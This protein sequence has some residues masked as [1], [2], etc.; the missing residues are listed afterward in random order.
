MG[1]KLFFYQMVC[2]SLSDHFDCLLHSNKLA[3]NTQ[4][5]V[6]DFLLF[7]VSSANRCELNLMFFAPEFKYKSNSVFGLASIFDILID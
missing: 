4:L 2:L 7:F 3:F 1:A 6:G 5:I